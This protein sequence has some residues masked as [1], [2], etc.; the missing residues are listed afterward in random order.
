MQPS[1]SVI[2]SFSSEKILL[3]RVQPAAT[4]RLL[5]PLLCMMNKPVQFGTQFGHLGLPHARTQERDGGGVLVG[6]Q[7]ETAC[8]DSCPSCWQG[9]GIAAV[10]AHS[11]CWRDVRACWSCWRSHPSQAPHCARRNT[12]EA[13]PPLA[14]AFAGPSSARGLI[15]L[16]SSTSVTSSLS[17]SS[18]KVLWETS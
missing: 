13:L 8:S 17:S 1:N 11:I 18:L 15:F 12:L 3:V 6:K 9:P 16:F 7:E 14:F 2:V 10:G 5:P 4:S